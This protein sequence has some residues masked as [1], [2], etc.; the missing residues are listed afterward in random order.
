MPTLS[1]TQARRMNAASPR[2]ADHGI[3]SLREGSPVVTARTVW[4]T[5]TARLTLPLAVLSLFVASQLMALGAA[6][7]AAALSAVSARYLASRT[8]R[9]F[10]GLL[11]A[12]CLLMARELSV[13]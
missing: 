6:L 5:W 8:S 7:L 10:A 2:D 1:D 13:P 9:I 4:L 11:T 12:L 3:P